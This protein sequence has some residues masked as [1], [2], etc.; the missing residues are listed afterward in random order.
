MINPDQQE[1]FDK[2]DKQ[3]QHQH[4]LDR[5]LKIVLPI[6]AFLVATICANMNIGSPIGTLIIL[7][8][9]LWM[10]TIKRQNLHLWWAI[11]L[12][13]CLID[14][15]LSYG[16]FHLPGFSRQFGTMF[17]F[18]GIFGIGRPY[19]DRWLMKNQ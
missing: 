15:W 10:V 9:A 8:I 12:I 5:V 19:M 17:I 6:V 16:A 2:L 18:V 4:K 3:Q 1:M 7:V 14:N 13:Y 11:I